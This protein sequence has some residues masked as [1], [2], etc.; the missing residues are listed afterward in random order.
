MSE[1][2]VPEDRPAPEEIEDLEASDEDQVTG[3][4]AY[5]NMRFEGVEG[6]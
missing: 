1:S 4:P 6:G 5:Q 3:G 2:Q